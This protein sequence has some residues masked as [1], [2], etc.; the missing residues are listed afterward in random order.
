MIMKKVFA[1]IALVIF[2]A[3]VYA[4][5][6]TLQGV[7]DITVENDSGALHKFADLRNYAH[8]TE[9]DSGTLF[10]SI[11]GQGNY[12]LI[13][14][15]IEDEFFLSCGA[16]EQGLLGMNTVTVS[17]TDGEGNT[18]TDTVNVNVVEPF[19]AQG[20]IFGAEKQNVVIEPGETINVTLSAENNT[21]EKEC[22]STGTFLDNDARD[23]ISAEVSND[24]FC[25]NAHENTSFSLSIT[26]FTGART[27]DYEAEVSL[28]GHSGTQREI[29]GV[30]V[31]DTENPLDIVRLGSFYVCREPYTQEIPIR[32]ENNSNSRETIALNAEHELLLP[33]FEFPETTLSAGGSDE[34]NLIIHTNAS[35]A[36][37]EYRIP[38]YA[39]S[40]NFYVERDIEFRLVECEENFFDLDVS[41]DKRSIERGS[42]QSFTITLKSASDE[43]QYVRLSAESDLPTQLEST[44]VFLP[45]NGDESVRIKV[46][47]RES[48]E[49]GAHNVK[50]Y[51][52]NS[53]EAEDETVKAIVESEHK[54]GLSVENND[55]EA[56]ACS[57]TAEQ[58]F[59]ITVKNNGDFNETVEFNIGNPHSFIQA[60]LS[61]E[62][63][64][65]GKGEEKKV[66]VFVAPSFDAPLGDYSISFNAESG[67]ETQ[68]EDLRFRVVEPNEIF[69]QNV[70]EVVSYPKEV[71]I[72]AGEEK[73][74]S[75]T[76]RN[77]S[78]DEIENVSLRVYGVDNGEVFIF[79]ISLGTLGARESVDVSRK[80]TASENATHKIYAATLE[81]KGA[82]TVT[83]AATPLKAS[84]IRLRQGFSRF[85]ALKALLW[86][87]LF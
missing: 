27:G 70:I 82:N 60:V 41:P 5:A 68:S 80:I 72:A 46:K 35:T 86:G 49:D 11:E 55:F 7:P 3:S 71:E 57:A 20:I 23:E 77:T 18:D 1:L 44:E 85:S 47:A 14:C 15:F 17:A 83:T 33:V 75:F 30:E 78:N 29:I 84:G 19:T 73:T 58:V 43:G 59:E 31:T 6:P 25:L 2:A 28:E 42:E 45:A 64:E 40:G 24:E 74:L 52:W 48:D 4:A 53:S 26:A 76:L 81:V 56:R 87:L 63:I 9:Q 22:F 61:D 62:S 39:R 21:D 36:L 66:Y 51:A 16:P 34:M 69:T 79:P 12:R 38:V 10:Y 65:L 37:T 32:L 8:D 13:D 54:I 50:V 67:A